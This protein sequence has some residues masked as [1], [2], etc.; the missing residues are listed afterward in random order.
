M[1]HGINKISMNRTIKFRAYDSKNG[2]VY[3]PTFMIP[4]QG[5][6]T[7]N[8]ILKIIPNVMQYTGLKDK[9]GFEIYEGD[10]LKFEA[11]NIIGIINWSIRELGFIL[12]ENESSYTSDLGGYSLE[13][14]EIIGNI[15]ENPELLNK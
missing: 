7:L 12:R 13:A 15:H 6:V 14:F 2:M 4:K 11:Q 9:K 1:G 10:I 5:Q 3:N 8:D